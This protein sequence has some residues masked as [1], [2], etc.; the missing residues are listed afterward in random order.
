MAQAA[1]WQ[2]SRVRARV[3][4]HRRSVATAARA[5]V[6]ARSQ[7][8]LLCSALLAAPLLSH[9]LPSRLLPVTRPAV[10]DSSRREDMLDYD[11]FDDQSIC[12]SRLWLFLCYVVSFA[13]VISSVWILLTDYGPK[14]GG[15]S[16][17]SSSWLGVVRPLLGLP[18]ASGFR[19][20]LAPG[21]GLTV[22][23]RASLAANEAGGRRPQHGS[24]PHL[25]GFTVDRLSTMLTTRAPP[26]HLAPLFTTTPAPLSRPL[27]PSPPPFSPSR[28][29]APIT[30]AGLFQVVLI[31]ASG[32]LFWVA[33]SPGDGSSYYSYSAF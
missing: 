7:T 28:P 31:L 15:G 25:H 24:Q 8:A 30:Q 17:G 5:R 19:N 11:A 27:P 33:R 3:R 16:G 14:S 23:P 29:L 1:A 12:R 10:D 18:P 2:L 22:L 26:T 13:A 6:C 20:A 21:G 4:A 9:L 32:L